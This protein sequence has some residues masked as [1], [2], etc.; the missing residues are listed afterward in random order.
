MLNTTPMLAGEMTARESEEVSDFKILLTA[1]FNIVRKTIND[2]VPK[3]IMTLLVNESTKMMQNHLI[4]NVLRRQ[5]LEEL[6]SESPEITARRKACSD[7]L[8]VLDQAKDILSAM[9]DS[10]L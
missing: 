9:R 10:I 1:Y 4:L 2:T 8:K 7:R 5:D 3:A 6:C